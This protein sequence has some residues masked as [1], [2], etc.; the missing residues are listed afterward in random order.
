MLSY[1]LPSMALLL[2]HTASIYCFFILYLTCFSCTTK[3]KRNNVDYRDRNQT[4]TA[5]FHL[6]KPKFIVVILYPMTCANLYL[7]K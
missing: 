2:P 5:G 6:G 7:I 4:I 3:H 1:A